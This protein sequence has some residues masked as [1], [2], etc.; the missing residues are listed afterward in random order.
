MQPTRLAVLPSVL[1]PTGLSPSPAY[2]S[3][4]LRLNTGGLPAPHLLAV[5]RLDSA[6]PL[7]VS[8]AATSGIAVAFSSCRYHDAS[9]P[10]VPFPG[11]RRHVPGLFVQARVNRSRGGSPGI[12]RVYRGP[13]SDSEI[14]GSE[15][16][17]VSPGHIA[18]CHVLLRRAGRAIPMPAFA[19]RTVAHRRNPGG[20][21]MSERS[22]DWDPSR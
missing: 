8:L 6:W 16:A 14:P 7:P 15:I 5:S 19:Y 1:S 21:W 18:A 13:K 2:R 20:R 4:Q 17:C 12:P 10:G 22:N 3:R 9:P 11:E